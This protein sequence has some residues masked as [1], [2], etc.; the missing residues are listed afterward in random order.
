MSVNIREYTRVIIEKDGQYLFCV[1]TLTKTPEWRD[2]P[3]DAWFTR[4]MFIARKVAA[5]FSA[6]P[7]LFNP[8][9]GITAEVDSADRTH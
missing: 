2:S 1:S 6:R 3:Y 7:V 5:L 8:V 4:K 9:V